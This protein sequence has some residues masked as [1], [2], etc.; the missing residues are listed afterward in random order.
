MIFSMNL[1][2][3]FAIKD[4]RITII[5]YW[6]VNKHGKIKQM[7]IYI[8][9]KLKLIYIH[10]DV[11]WFFFVFQLFKI[12]VSLGIGNAN[13]LDIYQL[14]IFITNGQG[15]KPNKIPT[16]KFFVFFPIAS[17]HM[18]PYISSLL[19]L[20]HSCPYMWKELSN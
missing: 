15:S 3:S 18:V 10:Y 2:S 19:M 1:K 6:C 14:Y 8:N 20:D 4:I 16:P 11:E 12:F 5:N 7:F 17:S 9:V 13:K